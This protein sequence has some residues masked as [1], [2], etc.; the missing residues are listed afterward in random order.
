MGQARPRV[1]R[2]S[3]TATAAMVRMFAAWSRVRRSTQPA[4]YARKVL[5]N[6]HL[7]ERPS[8][9]WASPACEPCHRSW[10]RT[11]VPSLPAVPSACPS[12][13]DTRVTSGQRR[14]VEVWGCEFKGPFDELA[15]GRSGCRCG[16]LPPSRVRLSVAGP[17]RAAATPIIECWVM[18]VP[19]RLAPCLIE[20]GRG[21]RR[22]VTRP[23]RR[24]RDVASDYLGRWSRR[25]NRWANADI[26][27]RCWSGSVAVAPTT[28]R[29]TPCAGTPRAVRWACPST[30]I[31][32]TPALPGYGRPRWRSTARG[33]AGCRARGD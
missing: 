2:F 16:Q 1:H 13:R 3:G 21:G 18:L 26:S 24:G 14:L 20:R 33:P 25:P 9:G 7:L 8:P 28:R 32:C 19:R 22:H 12:P 10:N 4:A 11:L 5:L 6:R 17:C 31:A 27:S 15:R 23:H 30:P 29:V